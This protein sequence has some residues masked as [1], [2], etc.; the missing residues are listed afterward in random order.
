MKIRHRQID[1]NNDYES[2]LLPFAD[3]VTFL[4]AFFV[5]L[6]S[7]NLLDPE[8][9][10]RIKESVSASLQSQTPLDQDDKNHPL[11]IEEKYT[12]ITTDIKTALNEMNLN[13]AVASRLTEDG[14]VLT[15]K[16]ELLFASGSD[17]LKPAAKGIIH[18]IAEIV[19]HESI[20][21]RI[22][23][24]TDDVPIRTARF[25][26][27]WELSS[28]RAIAVLKQLENANIWRTRLSATGYA[29]TRPLM[30][31]TGSVEDIKLAR[32]T[33]RRVVFVLTRNDL[34]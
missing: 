7:V 23:G 9:A 4:M 21:I 10:Q 12:Q 15:A 19:Q 31:A 32:D 28:Y 2:W 24:H 20:D 22:E 5:I 34:N 6:Y 26:S 33:N 18:S 11:T 13:D 30:N 16:S 29:D 14:L 3:M 27:N 25:P 17:Y 8:N 1:S